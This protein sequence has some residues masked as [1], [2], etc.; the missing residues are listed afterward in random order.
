MVYSIEFQKRGLLHAHIVLFLHRDD[1]ISNPVDIDKFISAEMPDKE[2]NPSLYALVT[3]LMINGPC[4]LSNS[5]SP[6]MRDGMCSKHFLKR[7]NEETF[8]DGDVYPCY[9]RLDIS[10]TIIKS[11]SEVDNRYVVLYNPS[12]ILK[13]NVHINVKWCNQSRA[14]NYLFKYINKEH[15]RIIE[16][17][18]VQI[19]EIH[20]YYNCRYVFASEASWRILRFEIHHRTP[21]VERL[22][23]V[24][25]DDDTINDV[26]SRPLN[27][28]SMFM[29]WIKCNK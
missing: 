18:L 27:E 9:K 6:C 14:I 17:Y 4:G 15:N 12:L 29:A 2:K 19:D 8:V 26:M 28:R 1:K 11:G 7:F 16:V 3:Y 22:T 24:F 21:S 5:R 23:V 13:Y 20:E 25:N 10:V